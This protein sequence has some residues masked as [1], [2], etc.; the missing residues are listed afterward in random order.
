M[1]FLDATRQ[2][3]SP[4]QGDPCRREKQEG[5][6]LVVAHKFL[7]KSR[8]EKKRTETKYWQQMSVFLLPN[9]QSPFKRR[10]LSSALV[11]KKEKKMKMEM[12]RI[13]GK[14]LL[15][16]PCSF[17]RETHYNITDAAASNGAM[18]RPRYSE[19]PR[20]EKSLM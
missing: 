9:C 1:R 19:A 17:N 18:I 20:H 2:I 14:K 16:L 8:Y 5:I 13:D 15:L 10:S 6:S 3:H 11:P 12:R 4:A 7:Q